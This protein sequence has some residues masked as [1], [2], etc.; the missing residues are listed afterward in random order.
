MQATRFVSAAALAAGL[1]L[2][3]AAHALAIT[4]ASSFFS[5]AAEARATN[6]VGSTLMTDA[7]GPFAF[8]SATSTVG[9]ASI[10]AR[11]AGSA[12]FADAGSVQ[13]VFTDIGWI[14]TNVT[15]GLARL[16]Q[17]LDWQYQF[18]IDADA[19]LS[20]SGTVASDARTTNSF[21]LN[22]F[23]LSVDGGSSGIFYLDDPTGAVSVALTPGAHSIRL[24]NFANIAANI[25][26][27][28][29]LMDATFDWTITAA[30]PEP[31]TLAL[32][33]L[34]LAGLGFGSRRSRS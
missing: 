28:T 6:D 32:V 21:G 8:V 11:G 4:P 17:G 33:G 26:T 2:S 13:I 18:S 5:M 25:G 23:G 14:S 27:R 31:G 15:N 20:V 24:Q 12:T 3:G 7:G 22:G 29:A 19:V 9:D 30:V 34:A 10:T 16:N 1:A